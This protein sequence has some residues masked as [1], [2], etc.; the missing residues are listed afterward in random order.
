MFTV[1]TVDLYSVCV[2]CMSLITVVLFHIHVVSL[3]D[4]TNGFQQYVFIMNEMKCAVKDTYKVVINLAVYVQVI[5]CQKC[6]LLIVFLDSASYLF[7][8]LMLLVFGHK[9]ASGL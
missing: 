5:I 8:A 1:F 9:S 2:Y 7:S 3:I 6:I 4:L